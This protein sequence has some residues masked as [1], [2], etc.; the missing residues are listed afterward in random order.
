MSHPPGKKLETRERILRSAR[1]LFN[2]KGFAE[3]T[4][5]DIMA[6]SGLTRGGF[7]KHFNTKEE[8]YAEAILQFGCDGPEPWQMAH[9]DPSAGGSEMARMIVGAY[10]SREHLDD[11]DGSCPLVGLP[12]DTARAGSVVKAAYRQVLEM[13]TRLFEINLPEGQANARQS[14]L[15]LVALCVGGMALS[16]ALD[17]QGLVD[18]ILSATRSHALAALGAGDQTRA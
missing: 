17:D 1:H 14:A 12:S 5:E 6:D 16:R 8:L 7:Y 2:R 13:M 18:E 3:V 15:S 10:L 9:V 4:I 11:R